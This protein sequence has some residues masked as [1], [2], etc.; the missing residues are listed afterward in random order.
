MF[1][2]VKEKSIK[3]HEGQEKLRKVKKS[4]NFA[5]ISDIFYIINIK[6]FHKKCRE[7]GNLNGH[8]DEV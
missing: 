3:F 2:K 7:N 6:Y 4:V 8:L 1:F 5:G